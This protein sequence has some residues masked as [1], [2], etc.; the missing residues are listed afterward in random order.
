MRRKHIIFFVVVMFLT[1]NML[2]YVTLVTKPQNPEHHHHGDV[3]V[4]LNDL[5]DQIVLQIKENEKILQDLRKLRDET[6]KKQKQP[7][8][9]VVSQAVPK[10]VRPN[11]TGGLENKLSYNKVKAD[12]VILPI[13]MIACNRAD[14]IQRSLD[15]VLKYRPDD[16]RFPIIVSQDCGHEQTAEMIQKYV[17]D[18][19]IIHIKQPDLGKVNVPWPQRK[20]EGYYKISRHYKWALN[21]VFHTYNHSAVIVVE[22]DLDISPDFFEYFAATFRVLMSDNS[23]WCVSA[24][25]DN[26][27][28]GMVKDDPELL[29][30]TDFFPGLGW[31]LERSMWLEL[32]P[33]WPEAFWDDWMRH[34]DQRKNRSCIRPEISRTSTFGKKGVSKGL[35]FEKHLKFIQLNEKYVPFTQKD[36]SYLIKENYD[37]PFHK[38]IY[39]IPEIS[40]NDVASDKVK[41]LPEVRVTYR[42]K[43]DFKAI[44][45]KLGIMDDFKAGVERTAYRGVVSFT[46]KDQRVHVAPPREWKGYDPTWT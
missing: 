7:S 12:N 22:D 30:R 15:L 31:M 21:Q 18:K 42:T 14:A 36:L 4:R 8:N 45:K 40:L 1:W 43:N 9:E 19:G 17:T 13:L 16:E 44:A 28:R 2:M 38:F 24:W 46:Y 29:H 5:Q 11:D 33:K 25:N 39:G 10:L 3:K 32:G 6:E 35:F 20:F 41:H 37:P 26:G 34:P 27:K 23:L